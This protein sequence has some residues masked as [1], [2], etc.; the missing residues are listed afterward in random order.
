MHS[1]S[2]QLQNVKPQSAQT[3]HLQTN[4]WSFCAVSVSS[5]LSRM[6]EGI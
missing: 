3:S 5:R 6:L 1:S 4:S 2:E